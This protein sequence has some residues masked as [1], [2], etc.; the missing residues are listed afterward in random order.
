MTE[1][2]AELVLCLT[3]GAGRAW[4]AKSHG[5]V[6]AGFLEEC[7]SLTELHLPTFGSWPTLQT[8]CLGPGSGF[9]GL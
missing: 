4:W 6:L 9:V 2:G 8:Y 1:Q 3:P 7:V 5:A